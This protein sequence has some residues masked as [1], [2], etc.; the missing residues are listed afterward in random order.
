MLCKPEG[1]PKPQVFWY[2]DGFRIITDTRVYFDPFGTFKISEVRAEDAGEYTC[3]AKN[4][5]GE[6][7]HK[8]VLTV[9]GAKDL[10]FNCKG[11]IFTFFF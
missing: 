3:K 2:K 4:S 5:A 9:T 11:F 1:V 8:F 6:A 10:I 7:I